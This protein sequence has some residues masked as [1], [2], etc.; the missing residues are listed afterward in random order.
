MKTLLVNQQATKAINVLTSLLR[1][2]LS[3]PKF[4][5]LLAQ[6]EGQQKH[7]ANRHTALA[8]YYY[9]VGQIHEA[10]TQLKLALKDKTADFY[11]RSKIEA[12]QKQFQEEIVQSQGQ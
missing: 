8:E 3:T 4:Y 6:A 10:L 11:Q 2:P 9:Q 12:R 5:Q 1:N 7:D